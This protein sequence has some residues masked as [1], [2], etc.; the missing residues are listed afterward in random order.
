MV[1][2]DDVPSGLACNCTC[3]GCG[4]ELQARH[5]SNPNHRSYFAHHQAAECPGGYETAVHSM[6]IQIIFEHGGITIPEKTIELRSSLPDDPDDLVENLELPRREVTFI[7]CVYETRVSQE[8]SQRL[9][10]PDL[11][12]TLKNEATLYIEVAVSHKSDIEKTR[13]LDNLMEIDLS[14]L[15]RSI[16]DDPEQFTNQVLHLAP[17]KWFQC[18]LYDKTPFVQK[19]LE[20]LKARHERQ[21]SQ[22]AIERAKA[23]HEHARKTHAR[24]RHGSKINEIHTIMRP[25][26]YNARMTQLLKLSENG[27][28]Y[29]QQRL[30]SECSEGETI[31]AAIHRSVPGD[32]LFNGHPIAWQGFV[33]DHYIFQKAPGTLLFADSIADAVV[34]AFG[35]VDWADKLLAESNTKRF[36]PAHIWFLDAAENE[37]LLKPEVVIGNYLESLSPPSLILTANPDSTGPRYLKR[38]SRGRQYEVQFGT[39]KEIQVATEEARKQQQER[40]R[41]STEQAEALKQMRIRDLAHAKEQ[42]KHDA[43]KQQL[44]WESREQSTLKNWLPEKKRLERNTK[45]L[46]AIQEH[47]YDHAYLCK[48]CHLPT[49]KRTDICEECGVGK[50]EPIELTSEYVATFEHRLRTMPR[51]RAKKDYRDP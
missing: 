29:A 50:L 26:G 48:Y 37:Q 23:D 43:L 36:S 39:L 21:Q 33:F 7:H 5:R 40:E 32:W 45:H 20:D 38:R 46:Q 10:R 31:P 12:A 25:A 11:T 17:R 6:A 19:R 14:K 1:R 15:P 35:V 41:E 8:E 18:S 2:P 3:P 34:Q 30:A 44:A 49:T 42:A 22:K 13:D 4:A 27:I 16:V 51:I 9:W 24:L 47:G 28:A